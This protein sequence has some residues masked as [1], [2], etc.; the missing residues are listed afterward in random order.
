M[1]VLQSRYADWKQSTKAFRQMRQET[2]RKNSSETQIPIIPPTNPTV[3]EPLERIVPESLRV[4]EVM[5]KVTQNKV[6]QR[7]FK[8]DIELAA[9]VWASK[10]NNKVPLYA[11]RDVRLGAEAQ[12][13]RHALQIAD[14]H[15]Q[16]WISIIYQTPKAYKAVHMI[17]LTHE[18]LRVWRDTLLAVLAQRHALLS[19]RVPAATMQSHWLS[20]SWQR[21]RD[22]LTLE[23][24]ARLLQRTNIQCSSH[25][26]RMHFTAA[27][28]D[29]DGVLHFEAFQQFVAA[30]KRRIDVE[31]L[32][33]E[34]STDGVL[35]LAAFQSF[36]QNEQAET[37]NEEEIARVYSRYAGPDGL[38]CDQ[39]L[40]FLSSRDNSPTNAARIAR[41]SGTD[42]A[43]E[44]LT[45]PLSDYYISSSHN[46]YL[47]GG[48][49]KGDSTVEGYVRA[50]QQGARSVELDCWDG[51]HGQPQVTHGRTLTSKVPFDDV[52]LAVAQYA[53]VASPYPLILSLEIHNDIAQQEAIAKSLRLHLGDMLVTSALKDVCPDTLP[54]PEQLRGRILV[55]F[56]NWTLIH[57]MERESEMAITELS[58]D[59]TSTTTTTN[60]DNTESDGESILGQA[61]EIFRHIKKPISKE[62]KR[63]V[64]HLM[65]PALTD[66]LVYTVGVHFRGINKK[67]LYAPEHVFSLS[68]RKA[69]RMVRQNNSDLIKHNVCHLTRVY[70][71]LSTFSRLHS[72]SAN[73]LPVDMWAAGCQL[74]ALNWQ[75]RDRGMEMNQAFFTSSNG[76]YRLKPEG[77]RVRSLLKNASDTVCVNLHVKI[78][79]AQQLPMLNEEESSAYVAMSVH[80]PVQWGKTAVR[81]LNSDGMPIQSFRTSNLFSGLAPIW[82]ASCTVQF[83]IPAAMDPSARNAPALREVT[84]GLLDLCFLRFQVYNELSGSSSNSNPAATPLASSMANLGLLKAG[85]RHLPLYDVQLSRMLYGTLFVHTHYT[86]GQ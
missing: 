56:K 7:T 52:I 11:I 3:L 54:S 33:T 72:S 78:V 73:F 51:P 23:D 28:K 76:G 38:S 58:V 83:K 30:L 62:E 22:A 44:C 24:V 71:S 65:S 69:V 53:F 79:S 36:V 49:W 61:R 81:L 63:K 18:S 50:L 4:G 16:R 25:D 2:P 12:S 80:V 42:E 84:R 37:W 77:L 14:R 59:S 46:T 41:S 75:T 27:D 10:K 66:L 26:L 45:N 55:K 21:D 1:Q 35:S 39:F 57:A 48:Q 60:T 17:A 86:L 85:Y 19:G 13:Y 8:V 68:E 43:S 9:I 6:A 32:F 5:L 34:R 31:N 70:P 15:E 29:R 40:A 67:E 47:V 64:E 82:N 20:A 74:V